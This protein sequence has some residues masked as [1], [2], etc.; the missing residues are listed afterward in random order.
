MVYGE[1]GNGEGGTKKHR[2]TNV[3]IKIT[4]VR[5]KNYNI[6]SE[7]NIGTRKKKG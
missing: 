1:N 3:L 2:K 7:M 4:D 6:M 5:A